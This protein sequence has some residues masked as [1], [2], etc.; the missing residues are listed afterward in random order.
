MKIR[1][2]SIAIASILV[3]A[4][5]GGSSI[6]PPAV[7]QAPTISAIPDQSVP[8]NQPSQPLSFTVA[9]EEVGNLSFSL[10]SDNA[11]VVPTAGLQLGGSGTSRSLT[12]TPIVDTTGDAFVTIV[13]TDSGGLSAG[14]SFLLTIDPQQ[15]SMQQFTRDAFGTDADDEPDFVNAIEFAQDADD[16]DFADLLAQ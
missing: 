14:T 4:C 10:M 5:D 1:Y 3:A 13:V 16:D 9:D 7:N 2:A 8:A 11:D 6:A 12:V 15:A